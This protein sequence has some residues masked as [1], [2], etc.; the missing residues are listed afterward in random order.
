MLDDK[1]YVMYCPLTKVQRQWSDRKKV[2]EEPLFKGFVFVQLADQNKW[3][4]KQIAG[5]RNFLYWLGKP[6]QVPQQ[7]IDTIKKFL[8]EFDDVTIVT[9]NLEANDAVLVKQGLLM[10]YEGIVVEVSGSSALVN[11]NSMGMQLKASFKKENLH[12]LQKAPGA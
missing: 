12:L 3:Q 1:G 5:V 9:N 6:A 7:E 2:V 8:Q 11:I 4:V 10:N